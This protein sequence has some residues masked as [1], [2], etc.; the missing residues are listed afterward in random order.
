[1]QVYLVGGAVRDRLLGRA[2]RERDWVVVGARPEELER[3]GFIPVGRDFPVFLHPETKEEHALARLERKIAPGYRG[4]TTEFSPH[5]T[6]E[7][8]LR[9]RDLTIN[10][11]AED[12]DGNI[13]DPHGGR[14]DLDARLLRHVSEA[15]AEDPVRI[16]R[17]ARFAARY[18][19]L[20]FTVADETLA[21]MRR[22]VEAGEVNALVAERVWAETEKAL[23]EP[24]PD[25]FIS[26]L[27][28]CGALKVIY[29]EIDALFGVPQ[30][31]KWH[32]EIDTGV[33]LLMAL[34][35]AVELGGGLAVRFAVLLHDLGKAATPAYV[36]PAHHG[37]EDSG[38]ALVE[39]LCARVRVPN[40]LRELAVIAARFHTHVHRALE[41]RADT[42]LRTLERCDALRRPE[43]F[44]EL[45]LACE[46]DA[47]GRLG[48]EQREYPQRAFFAQARE[49]AAAV[50]LDPAERAGMSGEKIG[51][52]LRRR[53]LAAIEELKTQLVED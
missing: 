33:H 51:Q 11:M 5:V 17:V 45:L 52:E 50:A 24:A 35:Q 31:Q 16:L 4:F 13:I 43:R 46:A 41:L 30:P 29:P 8:D 22:M 6:L 7:D 48:F 25:V 19:P 15:F 27:R 1:M 53:R 39:Q 14:R 42:V 12:A 2:V 20:G 9:R 40:H 47:R 36:L 26:V 3:Q 23:A 10:A 38:V 21:L 49:R 44:A 32:P 28:D 18:A 37:H 34:R